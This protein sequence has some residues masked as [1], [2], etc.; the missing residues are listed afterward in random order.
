MD[1]VHSQLA[2][3]PFRLNEISPSWKT[4]FGGGRQLKW[5]AASES[6][7]KIRKNSLSVFFVNIGSKPDGSGWPKDLSIALH[8][9]VNDYPRSVCLVKWLQATSKMCLDVTHVG[10]GLFS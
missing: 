3:G 9:E 7:E 2:T 8:G 1:N 6:A 5:H 4:A 10:R